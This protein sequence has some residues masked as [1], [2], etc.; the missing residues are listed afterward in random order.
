M[1]E[2]DDIY[3][4]MAP[5]DIPW[6]MEEPPEELVELVESGR[7]R[8]CRAVDLGCGAGN[9]A[10]YLAGKG[11][12]VTGIDIS[13]AAIKLAEEN[14]SKKGVECKFIAADLTSG[15]GLDERFDF[16]FEWEVLH[17]LFPEKRVKYVEN[18]SGL[19]NQGGLYLSVCFSEDDDP[20]FGG[21]G[22]YRTTK[23]GTE[24]YF[25]SEKEIEEDRKS[26]V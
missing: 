8:P 24:L 5:E 15:L 18:V 13:P 9:N 1:V 14:A 11:F 20:A 2:M 6:N 22:K 23:L 17:H 19:L 25:S 16:A 26:V 10:V 12:E 21:P 4:K 7:V 3:L